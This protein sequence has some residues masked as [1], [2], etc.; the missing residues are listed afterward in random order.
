M[1]KLLIPFLA[2]CF[3]LVSCDDNEDLCLRG[4]GTVTEYELSFSSFDMIALEGPINLRFRQGPVQEVSVFAEPEMFSPLEYEVRNGT[5]EIGYPD[6]VRCF[7][8]DYGVWVDVTVPELEAVALS[9]SGIVENDEALDQLSITVIISG[10]G[11][12]YLF[13]EVEHQ[14]LVVSGSMYADNFDLDSEDTELVVSGSAEINVS[15]SEMLDLE[16]SGAAVV[17]YKGNPQID[18]QVSGS[19]DLI[20]AN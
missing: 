9:G 4:S 16:I 6:N 1:K 20:N 5:L 2:G 10:E 11:E 12:V 14:R 15:C 19:L 7:E 3:F 17:R 18:Q 13:G 8:T